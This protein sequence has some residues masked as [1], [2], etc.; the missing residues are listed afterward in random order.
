ML[1]KLLIQSIHESKLK[2]MKYFVIKLTSI[3]DF[4][5]K[6]IFYKINIKYFLD[7]RFISVLNINCFV[8][9]KLNI[10]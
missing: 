1:L 6:I 5:E 7:E 3:N 2:L 9:L 4:S 10:F 8:Y